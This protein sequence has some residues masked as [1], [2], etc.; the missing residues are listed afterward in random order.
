MGAMNAHTQTET[1]SVGHSDIDKF[2]NNIAE[3]FGGLR[4]RQSVNGVLSQNITSTE[5]FKTAVSV[6]KVMLTV[7]W[8][9]KGVVHSESINTGTTLNTE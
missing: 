4:T 6:S 8:D 1:E 7:C 9:A 3:S 2:L 5:K